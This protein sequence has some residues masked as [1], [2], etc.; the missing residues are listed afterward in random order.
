[1]KT[2]ADNVVDR[3][4]LQTRAHILAEGRHDETFWPYLTRIARQPDGA[5]TVDDEMKRAA[6]NELDPSRYREMAG[7]WP[8]LRYKVRYIKSQIAQNARPAFMGPGIAGLA[9]GIPG[10]VTS[11]DQPTTAASGSGTDIWGTI[12]KV[13]AAAGTAAGSIYSSRI[14]A[15]A[16]KDI[17]KIQAQ[18]AQ[19]IALTQQQQQQLAAA[20]AA[21]ASGGSGGLSTA[22][23]ILLGLL[24][25]GG[26]VF[27]FSVISRRR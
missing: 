14:T 20:Q 12:G 7:K 22:M 23:Y 9:E 4:P 8:L 21:A 15:D 27:L 26:L 25:L 3:M 1:M 2:I 5:K 10:M 6:I 24:G 13:I 17:A 18:A 19:G 11:L 16:Q